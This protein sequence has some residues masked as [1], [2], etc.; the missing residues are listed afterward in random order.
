M[1][2][3]SDFRITKTGAYGVRYLSD[4]YGFSLADTENLQARFLLGRALESDHL[5]PFDV[6]RKKPPA[7]D[8]R[9]RII[10]ESANSRATTRQVISISVPTA[11]R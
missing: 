9:L 8:P 7:V 3:D 2:S 10:D 6:G 1:P 4:I 5:A 11:A